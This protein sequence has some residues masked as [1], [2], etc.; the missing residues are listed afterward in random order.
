MGDLF[1]NIGELIK[2]ILKTIFGN[3]DEEEGQEDED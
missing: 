2:S 3:E 1:D